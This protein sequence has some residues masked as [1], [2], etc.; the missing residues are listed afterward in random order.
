MISIIT[1]I[2]NESRNIKPYLENIN[3]LDGD[4]ELILV[5]G[6]S[7]DGTISAVNRYK[8]SFNRKI[9]LIQT[10]KGR[11][12]QMNSG[13]KIAKGKILLFLHVDCVPEKSSIPIIEKEIDSQNIIGGGMTQVFPNP[14]N[15]LRLS[16]N[17]GNLRTRITKI[18][19]GDYGI[20]IRK[21]IFEKIGGYDDIIFLEDVELSK[22]AKKFGKLKLLDL[23]LLTSPR[24]YQCHG[25]IKTTVI[26]ALAV[27][28]NSVG[29]RPEVFTKFIVDK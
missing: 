13:A 5:D 10:S 9:K 28:L 1:P 3:S 24:R 2:L 11:G 19:F 20:F 23:K 4:F 22:K 17:F 12:K 25:R 15:F 26:S 16:S 21:D 7:T 14:D 29:I 6:G 18:F 27:L 8:K